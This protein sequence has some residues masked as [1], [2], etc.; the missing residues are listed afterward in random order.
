MSLLID[1]HSTIPKIYG[2]PKIHEPEILLK[3]IISCIGLTPTPIIILQNLQS[4]ILGTISD[5]HIN[6]SCSFLHKITKINMKNKPLA[7]LDIKSLYTNVKWI[8]CLENQLWKTNITLPLT[9]SK[10]IKICT[11]CTSHCYFQHNNTFYKQKFGLPVGSSLCGVLTCI[12]LDFLE[13]SF[14]IYNYFW[15][16]DGILLTKQIDRI[17]IINIF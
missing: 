10:L 3:P 14:W 9:I 13:S 1:Y 12:Y 6:N 8:K 16:I 4:P 5:A 17:Q 15:Y 2:L 7:S 11:L